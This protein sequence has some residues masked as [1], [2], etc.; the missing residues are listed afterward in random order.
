MGD[1][2]QFYIIDE[3]L[4]GVS[5]CT[6]FMVTQVHASHEYQVLLE[7]VEAGPVMH[8]PGES[9]MLSKDFF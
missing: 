8:E 1:L 4:L 6:P 9:V 7:V 5:L 2:G 3:A